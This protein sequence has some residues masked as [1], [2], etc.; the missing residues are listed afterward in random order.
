MQEEVKKITREANSM[1][2]KFV[3]FPVPRRELAQA[4][5]FVVC[6]GAVCGGCG[7]RHPW[8]LTLSKN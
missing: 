5:Y 7:D 1:L 4:G 8:N 6:M 3:G 2:P